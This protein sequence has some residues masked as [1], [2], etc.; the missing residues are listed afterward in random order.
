[1]SEHDRDVLDASKALEAANASGD[2]Q[3]IRAAMA[4]LEAALRGEAPAPAPARGRTRRRAP[5]ARR[6]ATEVVAPARLRPSSA[7]APAGA[8][9]GRCRSAADA[10]RAAAEGDLV[11]PADGAD[12]AARDA[13]AEAAAPAAPPKPAP[14]PVVA[15]RG[16]DRPGMQEGRARACGARRQVRRSPR[17]PRRPGGPAAAAAIARG[18]RGAR[19]RPL[20]R[21]PGATKTAARAWAMPPSARSATRWSM[22]SS[23]CASWRR[24]PMARRSPSCWRWEQRDAEQLPSLQE[25]GRAV[26][27]AVRSGWSQALGAAP[28]GDASEALLRLEMAAEVP[29]PAEQLDARRALQLKLLTRRND[30]APAQTWGQDAARCWPRRTTRRTRAGCRTR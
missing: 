10:S 21:S 1:M 20:R 6:G 24:R 12:P 28:G 23:P 22:R 15:M 11:A 16:D 8:S 27:P 3:K 4:Q 13:D 14:K 17:R 26:S 25:L 30:P 5:T 2:A 18:D 29:T 19:R 9:A 7:R